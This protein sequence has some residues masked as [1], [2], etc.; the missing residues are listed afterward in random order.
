MAAHKES[1]KIILKWRIPEGTAEKNGLSLLNEYAGILLLTKAF[2]LGNI[3]YRWSGIQ[4][5]SAI[6]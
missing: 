3:T 5:H 1:E 4:K 2:A 6:L